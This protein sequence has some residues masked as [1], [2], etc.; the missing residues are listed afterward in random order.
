MLRV[1]L[2]DVQRL[3]LLRGEAVFEDLFCVILDFIEQFDVARQ[4]FL[5]DDRKRQAE[6]R[7]KSMKRRRRKKKKKKSK[8]L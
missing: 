6:K 5:K 4:K 3:E 8:I 2:V 7:L 1:N